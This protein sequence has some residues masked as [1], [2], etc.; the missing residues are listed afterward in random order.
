MKCCVIVDGYST[1]KYFAK[2]LNSKGYSCIHLQ[3]H[4]YQ[5]EI[6]R[7]LLETS[8]YFLSL[9]FRN[10]LEQIITFLDEHKPEF[11]IPG[12]EPGV[13]L[14]N[15]L[16]FRMGLYPNAPNAGIICRNKY[17][18]HQ[19]LAEANLSFI[20]QALVRTTG[21]AIAWSQT[22]NQWPI[23]VKPIDS[24]GM[25]GLYIC[26]NEK[27]LRLAFSELIGS[28]TIFETNNEEV[29]IQE[30]IDGEEY[31]VN[32]VSHNGTHYI[33]SILKY[34]RTLL[35][36]GKFVYDRSDL[37]PFDQFPDHEKSVPYIF[38]V[39]NALGIK[40]GATHSE[41][42]FAKDGPVL[43]ECNAR[44]MGDAIPPEVFTS[45]LNHNQ[46]E[47]TI[48]SYTNPE[49]FLTYAENPYRL[50][51]NLT[52]VY[53][54]A[55]HE[56]YLEKVNLEYLSNLESLVGQKI[57]SKKGD[58]LKKTQDL[59]SCPGIIFLSHDDS[60]LITKDYEE[61]RR[62]EKDT[63]FALYPQDSSLYARLAYS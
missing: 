39:L 19:K 34:Q 47:L 45:C 16:S 32:T 55:D 41:L 50:Q 31:V 3:S 63:L 56:G 35:P 42:I 6:E 7:G 58:F 14:A 30:F 20:K 22:H 40:Y 36:N 51:K 17:L 11:I 13:T 29:L 49:S 38:D 15:E 9:C 10:N 8:D 5:F 37:I 59:V 12:S 27:E 24:G 44:V 33:D 57:S 54:I 25:D 53:L 26:N 46:V 23:V 28:T 1:G 2:Y 4:P 60:R 43:I 52:L 61:I 18:M 62:L 48:Q 21:E